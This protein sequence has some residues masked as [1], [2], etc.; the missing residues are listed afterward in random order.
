MLFRSEFRKKILYEE[1]NRAKLLSIHEKLVNAMK[2]HDTVKAVDGIE[3]HFKLI[4]KY[5]K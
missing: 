1:N 2:E 5:Y 4:R 3:E